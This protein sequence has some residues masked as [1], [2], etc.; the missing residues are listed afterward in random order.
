MITQKTKRTESI[1]Y[2]EI[3]SRILFENFEKS[4]EFCAEFN[5]GILSHPS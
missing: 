5:P 4:S 3:Y 2:A 1:F